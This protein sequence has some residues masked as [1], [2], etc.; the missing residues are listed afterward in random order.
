MSER[1]IVPENVIEV[2]VDDGGGS[3]I[4]AREAKGYR[5]Q[6]EG[7]AHDAEGYADSA[8]ASAEDAE[9]SAQASEGYCDQAQEYAGSAEQNARQAGEYATS[10]GNSASQASA[11]A[12]SASAS[13]TLAGDSADNAEASAGVAQGYAD[14]ASTAATQASASASSAQSSAGQA[15]GSATDAQLAAE[16][17]AQSAGEAGTYA[18]NA[19]ASATQAAQSATDADASADDASSYAEQASQSATSASGSATSAANS[20]TSASGSATTATTAATQAETA[21]GKAEEAQAAAEEAQEATEALFPSGGTAGQVLKKTQAGSEWGDTEWGD[22]TGNIANQTDLQSALNGKVDKEAGKGLSTNDYDNTAKGKLNGIEEGAEVNDVETVNGI[23]PIDKNVTLNARDIPAEGIGYKFA[24]GN[25]CVIYDGIAEDADD[26][27]VTLEPIQDLHG[28]DYP[29]PP[30]G[31]KNIIVD[32]TDTQNGFIDNSYLN[33]DGTTTSSNVVY[34]SEYFPVVA[35]EAYSLNKKGTTSAIAPCLYFYDSNKEFI[36]LVQYSGTFPQTFTAPSNAAYCRATQYKDGTVIQLE[37]GSTPTEAMPYSNICSITGRQSAL[38]QITKKNR[39]NIANTYGYDAETETC[40]VPTGSLH[41]D[42]F[43]NGV[44]QNAVVPSG[45][46]PKLPFLKAGT[47]CYSA[48]AERAEE[49]I[50]PRV[51]IFYVD[52]ETGATLKVNDNVYS[53]TSFTLVKDSYITVRLR[54]GGD[55]PTIFSNVQIE[56]GSTVTEY[57]PYQGSSASVT[58]PQTVYGGTIDVTTGLLKLDWYESEF[59]AVSESSG[60][61]ASSSGEGS[62][63]YWVS[64]RNQSLPIAKQNTPSSG[65]DYG[66]FNYGKWRQA[67]DGSGWRAYANNNGNRINVVMISNTEDIRDLETLNSFIASLPEPLQICYKLATPIEIQLTPAQ[68]SLL[69]GTNILTTDGDTVHLKYLGSDASNV[70]R[71]L[72]NTFKA[73]APVEESIATSNHAVGDYI[74]FQTQFCKVTQAISV[75]E[76]VQIGRNVQVTTVAAEL[77][78]ILAQLQA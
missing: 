6:A 21:Q 16:A 46:I 1:I 65:D 19:S 73:F 66:K 5:D 56:A 48:N 20:A 50:D 14:D 10:A 77:L 30:G 59:S 70:Q 33:K 22:V 23:V 15:S 52:K 40:V 58:F 35:S 18:G 11:S 54:S 78:A 68:L 27:T 39:F 49:A 43:S 53:G 32:G 13:A 75:G 64:I 31:S 12:Q 25:P 57:E 51:G 74:S 63:M 71:V 7:F 3:E 60:W 38:V 62:G 42:L 55:S 17:S 28:H 29:W 36:S 9:G 61:Y 44:G 8:G 24:E 69:E 72:D 37:L 26:V 41:R 76:I 34:V 2:Q 4:F 47:Y 67:S 45:I